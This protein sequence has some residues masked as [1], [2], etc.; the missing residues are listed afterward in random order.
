MPDFIPLKYGIV[1]LADPPT[2]EAGERLNAN[3]VAISDKLALID[4]AISRIVATGYSAYVPAGRSS[5]IN[6]NLGTLDVAVQVYSS[7]GRETVVPAMERID[8]N[9]VRLTFIGGDPPDPQQYR[10]VVVRA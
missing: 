1:A 5:V 8:A 2:G 9:S 7:A 10:V 4:S 3:F 6:H